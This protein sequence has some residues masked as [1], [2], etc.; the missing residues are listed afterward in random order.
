M[1]VAR[2]REAVRTE[3]TAAVAERLRPYVDSTEAPCDAPPHA[4][5]GS[6]PPVLDELME[7]ATTL[8]AVMPPHQR[9]ATIE[10]LVCPRNPER[11]RMAL[12]A[13]IEGAFVVVDEMGFLRRLRRYERA[14]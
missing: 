7:R 5:S 13:L 12:D 14:A 4:E 2:R 1:G 6:A 9:R 11:A 10:E 3:D 8:L